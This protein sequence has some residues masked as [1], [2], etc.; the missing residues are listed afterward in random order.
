MYTLTPLKTEDLLLGCLH[1]EKCVCM[2][3][4]MIVHVCPNVCAVCACVCVCG[5]CVWC[6]CV[7]VC[8]CVYV[9]V[10][11]CTG[12]VDL[13]IITSCARRTHIKLQL[14]YMYT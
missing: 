13:L 14:L 4:C 9:C 11:V 12:I 3:A 10:G 7:C 8:V 2:G 5:V 1:V 6:V